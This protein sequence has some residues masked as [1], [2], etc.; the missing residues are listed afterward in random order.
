VAVCAENDQVLESTSLL[1][2]QL[3][4]GSGAIVVRSKNMCHLGDVER[5]TGCIYE[6]F[7]R[8]ARILAIAGGGGK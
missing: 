4:L 7:I 2:A 8:A 1:F 6:E 5:F 3:R